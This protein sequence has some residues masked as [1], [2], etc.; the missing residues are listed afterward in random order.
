MLKWQNYCYYVRF[1]F[2]SNWL[3]RIE[4]P[5][6][7]TRIHTMFKIH[8]HLSLR[9]EKMKKFYM[10]GDWKSG[11]AMRELLFSKYFHVVVLATLSYGLTANVKLICQ[12]IWFW[13]ANIIACFQLWIKTKFKWL[14]NFFIWR[15]KMATK[16]KSKL[17]TFLGDSSSSFSTVSGISEFK[18]S[19]THISDER[20]GH[21]KMVTR[22]CG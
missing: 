8:T 21:P 11:L 16:I 12:I 18:C 1:E 19:R 2:P 7:H 5:F 17:E 22:N 14:P 20:S 13:Q 10:Y 9:M 15:E 3:Y 6:T 4:N